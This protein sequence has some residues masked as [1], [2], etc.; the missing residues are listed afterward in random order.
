MKMRMPV[1]HNIPYPMLFSRIIQFQGF[2][3][4]LLRWHECVVNSFHLIRMY[5]LFTIIAKPSTV[6]A[7]IT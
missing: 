3:L 1:K 4:T 7:L 6:F 5:G 2:E